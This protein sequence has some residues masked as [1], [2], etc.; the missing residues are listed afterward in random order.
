MSV[1]KQA[2]T[3]FLQGPTVWKSPI[4]GIEPATFRSES[5]A[6]TSAPRDRGTQNPIQGRSKGSDSPAM[7][8]P[9]L[10]KKEKKRF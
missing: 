9:V 5:A 8:G 6:L 2:K 1:A 10:G 4:V 7:A 3:A